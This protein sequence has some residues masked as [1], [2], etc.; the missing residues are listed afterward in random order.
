MVKAIDHTEELYKFCAEYKVKLIGEYTNV[1]KTTP[2]YFSCFQC[3]TQVKKSYKYL[4]RNKDC[5]NKWMNGWSGIC[6]R[7]FRYAVH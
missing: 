5:E 1:K 3:G 2:I 6:S 4:T 7:C